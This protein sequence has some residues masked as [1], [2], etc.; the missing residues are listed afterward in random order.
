MIILT[1]KATGSQIKK[2]GYEYGSYIKVVVDI[3][4]GILCGGGAMHYDE[5]QLMLEYGCKQ[6]NLWGGGIDLDTNEVTYDSMI[7]IR[8][9]QGNNKKEIESEEIRQKFKGIVEKLI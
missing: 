1:Q 6:S 9:H 5:E 4:K 7:N 3:E 2:M 8:P